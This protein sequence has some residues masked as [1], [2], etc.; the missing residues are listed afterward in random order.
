M[1]HCE[2]LII[3]PLKRAF[4]NSVSVIQD[5]DACKVTVPFERVDQDAITLWI[6]QRD[7]EY[8]VSDEGE[9]YGMLYLSNINL[10]QERRKR[11]LQSIKKRFDLNE[12]KYEIRLIAD[13]KSLGNRIIDAIQ[14]VQSISHLLYTRQQYTLSD[15]RDDVGDFLTEQSYYYTPNA[16]TDGATENHRVDSAS[17]A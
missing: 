10:D 4:E 17:M 12:A 5:E 2:H 6:T 9:T 7:D 13:E 8:V 3:P 16:E 15:F 11:R 1:N 14:A